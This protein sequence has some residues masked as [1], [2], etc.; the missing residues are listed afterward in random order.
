MVLV[1]AVALAVAAGVFALFVAIQKANAVK[2]EVVSSKYRPGI[3][4]RAIAAASYKFVVVK[5]KVTNNDSK[6]LSI[7]PLKDSYV[8]DKAGGQY[9]ASPV[10]LDNEFKPIEL[11]PSESHT[12]EMSYAVPNDV[13]GLNLYLN[14]AA[15]RKLKLGLSPSS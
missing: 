10:D 9:A 11:N 8:L 5:F 3:D 6:P 14:L 4:Q 15:D 7:N 12:G 1:A 2:V 13:E